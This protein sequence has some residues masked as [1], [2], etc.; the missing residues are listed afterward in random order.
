MTRWL[1]TSAPT[2]P[3]MLL[4]ID[5]SGPWS[6][7][8]LYNDAGVQAE[9]GWYTARHQT[10]QVMGQLDLLCRNLG[11]TPAEITAVAVAI[12][13]GSWGGL[14]VGLSLSKALV[15]ARTLPLI[16]IPTSDIL[17]WSHRAQPQAVVAVVSVGRERYA[18]TVYPP[19]SQPCAVPPTPVVFALDDVP[20]QSALYVGDLS[21]SLRAHLGTAA[22]F[23]S[24]ADNVRRPAALAELGWQ[25]LQAGDTDDVI[26]LEPLYLSSPIRGE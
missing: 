16:G 2:L 8:A 22:L 11:L 13:P 17:A 7:L 21:P 4:A 3:M 6:G 25:R 24:P 26:G 5:T 23:P 19:A 14:R 1:R 9:S 15:V 10:D 18:I 12:G 20:V